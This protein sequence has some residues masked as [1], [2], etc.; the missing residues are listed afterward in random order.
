MT[1]ATNPHPGRPEPP[2][3]RDSLKQAARTGDDAD[4][5]VVGPGTAADLRRFWVAYAVSALGSGVGTGALP[6]VAVLVLHVSAWQVSQLAVLAGL[7]GVAVTIPLGARIEFR[8]KRPTMIGADLVRFAALASVPAAAIC[9]GLTYWQLCLAAVMQTAGTIVSTAAGT[10]Y[11]K[12]L[13][14]PHLRPVV[15]S[16][17]ETTTWTAG[18]LGPPAGG[19]LATA[20]SP[21]ASIGVDAASFLLSAA[22]WRRIRHPESPP[23]LPGSDRRM[24]GEMVAGWRHIFAH[25]VLLRLY[26][27]AA[28][29]GGLI[30][31]SSPLIAVYLLRNLHLSTTAYGI[32]LGVPCAAG[33]LGSL[34]APRIIRWAGLTRTL[35]WSGAARCVW[36]SPILLARPGTAGLILIIT[37]D[38]ALLFCA[39]V[40]NPVFGTYRMNIT[41]DTHLSRVVAAWSMTGK[42]AQPACIAA[43][44]LL[45]TTAGIRTAIGVLSVV[46]LG[47]ALLLPWS[48]TRTTTEA[49]DSRG[50]NAKEEAA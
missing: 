35:V 33:A 2:P 41:A 49:D 10:S 25:P 11:L 34:L 14:P 16:R 30:M 28:V 6:L 1:T 43:A 18:S 8:R 17:L 48:T 44:G 12:A 47:T 42:V 50:T 3:R 22:G 39:G 24:L 32:T 5:T 37:A 26:L 40:F 15:N 23:V 29:F 46:L 38:S 19:L 21:I 31:A 13:T 36:M 27:N 9:G 4:R 45:A 7:A 20:V